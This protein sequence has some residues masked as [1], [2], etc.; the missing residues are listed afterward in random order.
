MFIRSRNVRK[1]LAEVSSKIYKKKPKNIIAVTG[2]NGKSSLA[3]FYYQILRLNK[4]KVASIGTLGV[5]SKNLNISLPNTTI[6]PIQMGQILAKLKEKID[7]VIIEASSHG[8]EQNR[9]DG[10][11]F[12]S[13]NIHKFFT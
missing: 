4:K 9:L 7:N 1:L 10:L 11:K 5:K 13:P 3:N 2:T 12:Q 6:D 8:L